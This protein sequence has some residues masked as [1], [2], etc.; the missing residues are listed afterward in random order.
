VKRLPAGLL[1]LACMLVV[2]LPGHAGPACGALEGV[3][4]LCPAWTVIYDSG[5]GQSVDMGWLNA[6]SPDGQT[7]FSVGRTWEEADQSLSWRTIAYNAAS[8][9]ERWTAVFDGGKKSWDWPGAMAVSP[10][11]S[12]VY[13]AG[14]AGND[15]YI[16]GDYAIVAYDTAEGD[17]R[18]ETVYDHNTGG[19]EEVHGIE[20]SPDGTRVYVTGENGTEHAPDYVTI[21]VDTDSGDVAWAREYK[22]KENGLDLGVSVA[23][24]EALGD[25]ARHV[26]Y[27]TGAST[28]ATMDHATIAYDHDGEQ[29]WVTRHQGPLGEDNGLYNALSPDGSTLYVTGDI[30]IAALATGWDYDWRTYAIDTATGAIGWSKDYTGVKPGLDRPMAIA[31]APD[32]SKLYVSGVVVGEHDQDKEIAIV[33]YDAATG[34]QAWESTNG[35]PHSGSEWGVTL[36]ISPDG[37]TLAMG[38]VRSTGLGYRSD[39]VAELY[40]TS[41]GA[42]IA[43]SDFFS[44][45]TPV[46]AAMGRDISFDPSGERLFLTGHTERYLDGVGVGGDMDM[47]TAAYE[48]G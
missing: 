47:F 24:G 26:V 42:R 20:L 34:T 11:G 36:D 41:D 43:A 37:S 28:A 9:A 38:G 14:T 46:E 27:V 6:V 22:V 12:T 39:A 44:G 48:V 10:D 25:G 15:L 29:L 40:S 7:V 21:A 31:L 35:L 32:G 45:P 3:D 23:V 8:G 5:Q 16:D 17:V 30:T 1:L 13:V 33:A 18:W 2:P 19:I 4:D